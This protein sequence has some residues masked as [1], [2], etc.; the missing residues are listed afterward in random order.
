M[1]NILIVYFLMGAL[2]IW[3]L[4]SIVIVTNAIKE[5]RHDVEDCADD[6]DKTRRRLDHLISKVRAKKDDRV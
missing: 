4:I 3:F 1:N 6:N 5:L 2:A